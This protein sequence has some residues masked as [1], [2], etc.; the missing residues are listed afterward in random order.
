MWTHF[1]Y[2]KLHFFFSFAVILG[3]FSL[4]EFEA[5]MIFFKK[6]KEKKETKSR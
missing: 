6:E 5:L 1:P 3:I 2:Y 4:L